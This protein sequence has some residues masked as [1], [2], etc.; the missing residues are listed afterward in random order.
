MLP[1]E[2]GPGQLQFF[3]RYDGFTFAKYNNY[4][5]NDISWYG[6]GF[7]YYIHG[8]NIKI[9]GQYSAVD[10]DKEDATNPEYQDYKTFQLF[11]QVRL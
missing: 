11:L 1:M 9:T 5:D 10:F 3:Y 2:V 7:N 8:Q 4:Y 6:V